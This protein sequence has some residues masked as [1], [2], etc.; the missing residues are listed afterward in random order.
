MNAC[1]GSAQRLVTADLRDSCG[2]WDDTGSL[3]L[4]VSALPGW[5]GVSILADWLRK[6][7]A[8]GECYRN[9]RDDSVKD[10][11]VRGFLHPAAGADRGLPGADAQRRS[12]LPVSSAEGAGRRHLWG[13]A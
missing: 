11:R 7:L 13:G 12:Q 5:L 4:K 2:V 8:M 3:P 6:A 1:G 9:S 10:V